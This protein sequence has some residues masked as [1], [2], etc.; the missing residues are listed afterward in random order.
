[1]SHSRWWKRLGVVTLAAIVLAGC[2]RD[3]NVRKQ[4]YFES[5]THYFEKQ[6]YREAAIQ[7]Q[8]T[9]QTDPRYVDAHY[10]LAQC[11]LKLGLW[12]NAYQELLRT[13]DLKPDHLKG[14]Q[15]LGV[16]LLASQKFIE[17]KEKAQLVLQ[18]D[19]K[20]VDAHL[21]LA[22]A[23]AGLNNLEASLREVQEAIQ[24]DPN[25]AASYLNQAYL[26][27]TVNQA[28]LAEESFKKAVQ[29]D[30]KSATAI[31]A[32][33]SLYQ[34]QRRWPEAEQQFRRAVEVESKSP[35]PRAALARLY[36]AEGQN[37]Q[38][39]QVLLEA[40]K[41]LADNSEG[42]RMLGDFYFNLGQLDK[43]V[44]EY[45]SLYR[46]HPKDLQ[47]KKNY[48]Q[49]LILHG[50]LDEATKLN[51][52]IL[53]ANP[54]D[55]DALI[56]RG[57]ILNR[58]G[59]P[60]D[61]ILVLE[62]AL[63]AEPHSALGHYHLG[64]AYSAVGNLARAESE[65]REA[66]RLRPTMTTAQQAL[67]SIALRKGNIDLLE[68]AAEALINANPGLPDGYVHRAAA[69]L[70]RRNVPGAEADLIKAIDVAPQ[71]PLGFSRLGALRLTQKRFVESEKLFEQA[72]ERDPNFVEAL[73]GLVAS[74]VQQ[75][76]PAKG[77]ARVNAQIVRAPENGAYYVLLGGLLVNDKQLDKAE[78]ALQKAAELNNKD[79]NALLLLAQV[80]TARGSVD[81]AVASYQRSIEQNPREPR[82]YFML[83]A[84]EDGRKNWQRAQ[85]LY[86]KTLQVEPDF[87]L[88]ANNLAYLMIEHGGNTDVALSLAQTARQKLPDSTHVADTL[89][90]AYYHKGAYKLAIGLLEEAVKKEP[91][92]PT[93]HF[94]LGLAYRRI[95]DQTHAKAHLERALQINPKFERA[96]EIRKALA[97]LA[98]G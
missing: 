89:A 62:P 97:E 74:Y 81:K 76:Q 80:Q 63:K 10:Q 30:P 3:P 44:A 71:N 27:L 36:L 86:Q 38:A 48:V 9:I 45:A 26:Q 94:H 15:D 1:M 18:K 5:G 14:Q 21:L 56:D 40:K 85:E 91:Q 28:A 31:T 75:K 67:A 22:N 84:L 72:L 96:D 4:K 77:L 16:M 70:A 50:P 54:K 73:Q 12:G 51:D 69:R 95:N 64:V 58:Q 8:N 78:A 49:L 90:W 13:V 88:A 92:D 46:E 11:Y 60:N 43:A 7:F 6:Q 32:L 59:R 82:S 65:W 23:D 55:M 79:V 35:L 47:V 25:R 42:Y 20:N 61:A 34:Q 98:R 24:L 19:P 87:P 17:A 66:V 41:A 83:G 33:G 29:L 52:E 37:A 93:F 39:E 53:K 57:Q 2:S 68:K